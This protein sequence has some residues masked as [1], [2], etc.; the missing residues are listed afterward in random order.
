[1]SFT[2]KSQNLHRH[3]RRELGL[4]IV[5]LNCHGLYGKLTEF[6]L[7]LYREKP[8]V[9]C[10]CE[11]W[12]QTH[13]PSFVGYFVLWSH[14]ANA[15]RGGLAI[16]IC[17]DIQRQQFN[18]TQFP[19]DT[20]LEY[21]AIKINTALGWI[22]IANFYNPGR[23]VECEELTYYMTQLGDQFVA[24]GDFNAHSP[25]WDSRGRSNFT[26]R[27]LEATIEALPICLLNDGSFPTY[28]DNRCGT[29]SCLD[30]VILT[31]NLF[32]RASLTQG[33]DLGSDHFPVCCKIGTRLVRSSENVPVRW[34]FYRANWASYQQALDDALISS[35]C[36]PRDAGS[37]CAY[38]S[39]AILKAASQSVSR[40]SGRRHC[41]FA[42]PWWD[43]ECSRAVA[44]RRQAKG[45][46]WR[47]PTPSNL[48]EYKRCE[49]VAR[50]LK[51][52]KQRQ[53][54]I[55]YVGT[56]SSS[57]TTKETWEKI[58]SIQGRPISYS[59]YPLVD[60]AHD[61][62]SAKA[63][64]FSEHFLPAGLSTPTAEAVVSEVI[65]DISRLKNYHCVPFTV[66]EFSQAIRALK[67]TAPGHDLIMNIFFSKASPWCKQEL[68]SLFNTS[69]TSGFVPE[70]WKHGIVVP[71]PKPGK[72]PEQVTGYRPITLL[73]C[74]GKL[75]ERMVLR[76][77]QHTLE[78]QNV[79]S[80]L[81][82]GFRKGK[83]TIDALHLMKNAIT[84][85]QLSHEYCLIVYLDIEG[86]FDS[87]W[88]D[89][90]LF[91]LHSIGVGDQMLAWLY[92]YFQ[93]RTVQVQVGVD[94]SEPKCWSPARCC[95]FTNAFQCDAT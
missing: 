35:E 42:T 17:R 92:S 8:D 15:M 6:K 43:G 33:P 73:P 1:M 40:S 11:T 90:L 62:D 3:P 72:A 23:N 59:S 88:H 2:I 85:A 61:D 32:T 16:L 94:K 71:I 13:E 29:T 14:R 49:A 45:K 76:R 24:A 82:L 51:L 30:L 25:L 66:G 67:N 63:S 12:V 37:G 53:S 47:S 69:W 86:A 28:I 78:S 41:R 52:R 80:S 64:L 46:L 58:R 48:I 10:L 54:W 91:K 27:S 89:G 44:L 55:Q 21:Q 56:I 26:G 9:V 70:A 95:A 84:L 39:D 5:Q 87:V 18:L 77:L 60:A 68:L 4:E 36:G 34:K 7:Y 74:M 38:L 65:S 20:N 93:N 22:T 31:P 57:T 75:M 50:N 81:H 83:S 79:F 19:G